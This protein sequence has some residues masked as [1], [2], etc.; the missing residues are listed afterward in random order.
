MYGAIPAHAGAHLAKAPLRFEQS[1]L[2]F[3]ALF[4]LLLAARLCHVHVLWAEE[5]LPLATAQRCTPASSV[6][7]V[8]FDKPQAH[9]GGVLSE[10]RP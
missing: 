9:R 2:T 4:V 7:D 1:Q 10:P 5:T 8:W 6:R 3:C